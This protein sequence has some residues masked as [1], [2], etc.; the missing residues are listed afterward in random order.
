MKA[1]RFQP[2]TGAASSSARSFSYI[3]LSFSFCSGTHRAPI[4]MYSY[5]SRSINIKRPKAKDFF[6]YFLLHFFYICNRGCKAQKKKKKK[7][8]ASID[9]CSLSRLAA[10]FAFFFGILRDCRLRRLL[11][12]FIYFQYILSAS[13]SFLLS[14]VSR[15]HFTEVMHKSGWKIFCQLILCYSVSFKAFR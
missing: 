11:L 14:R 5:A 6:Y 7:S 8:R 9:L 1:F 10:R 12:L 2:K 13:P 3:F 15:F 4:F